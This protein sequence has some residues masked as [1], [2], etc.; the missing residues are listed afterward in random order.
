MTLPHEEFLMSLQRIKKA[1]SQ[2]NQNGIIDVFSIKMSERY[3]HGMLKKL[4][5][6]MNRCIV[7]FL[8]WLTKY[9]KR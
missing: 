6:S 2:I 1:L 3:F 5:A 8:H 4:R 7:R 9:K